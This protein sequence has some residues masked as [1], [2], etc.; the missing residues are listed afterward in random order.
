MH[1]VDDFGM[2][3][4]IDID[5]IVKIPSDNDGLLGRCI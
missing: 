5:S 1:L 4:K 3:T 2:K